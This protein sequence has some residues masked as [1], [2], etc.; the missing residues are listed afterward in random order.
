M[1]QSTLLTVLLVVLVILAG[2]QS[3]EVVSLKSGT[4]DIAGRVSVPNA[5]PSSSSDDDMSSH[6]DGS[7]QGQ[8][9]MV[10]GC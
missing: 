2:V 10:G 5:Q 3:I 9:Q 1:K 4:Q 8:S 6:H 7:Q